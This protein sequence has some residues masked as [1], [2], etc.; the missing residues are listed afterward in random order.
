MTRILDSSVN[1]E[2][3][4]TYGVEGMDDCDPTSLTI[5]VWDLYGTAPNDEAPATAEGTYVAAIVIC[6]GCDKGV[7]LHRDRFNS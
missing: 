2:F 4:S 5:K 1:A 3:L 6:D 7:E